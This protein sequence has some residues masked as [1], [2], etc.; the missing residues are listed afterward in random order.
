[1]GTPT[2]SEG[3]AI[4]IKSTARF[5]VLAIV[6]L[7]FAL[8]PWLLTLIFVAWAHY[9]SVNTGSLAIVVYICDIIVSM[10]ASVLGAWAELSA[11]PQTK[12][13]NVALA[14][15]VV[16]IANLVMLACLLLPYASAMAYSD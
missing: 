2:P 6:S 13:K 7:I 16:G 3:A 4:R 12:P 8:A 9:A 1:M 10:M 5:S 15:A 14:A 11:R